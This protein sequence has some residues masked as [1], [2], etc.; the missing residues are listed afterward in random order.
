MDLRFEDE[1]F[2]VHQQM[3][4]SSFY[5]LG[6]VETPVLP[7]HRGALYRLGVHYSGAGLGVPFQADPE[8][9]SRMARLTLSQVPSLSAIS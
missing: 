7:A 5:L 9:F 3:P 4:L 6:A 1:A 2:G 8:A